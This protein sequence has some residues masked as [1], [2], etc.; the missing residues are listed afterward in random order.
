MS[1]GQL[2]VELYASSSRLESDMGKAAQI[3]ESRTRAMDQA[4][5]RARKSIEGIGDAAGRIGR[6]EGMRQAA[7]EMEHLS[8]TTVGARREMLVL[9]HEILTGNYKR[10]MGSFMVLGERM[11]WMSKIAPLLSAAM[12][13]VGIALGVAAGGAVALAVAFHQAEEESRKFQDAL[14]MTGHY[15]GVTQGQFNDMARRTAEASGL[16]VKEA[17]EMEMA[18]VSSG[19]FSGEAL[20]KVTVLAAK[21]SEVT[22]QKAEEVVRE[23]TRMTDG[24]TKYALESNRQYHFLDVAM[25]EHIKKLE[26]EGRAEDAEVLV[27][28][29]LDKKFGDTTKNVGLLTGAINWLS[30]AWSSFKSAV[31]GGSTIDDRIAQLQS[32]IDALPKSG[33]VTGGAHPSDARVRLVAALN[34][35][36]KEKM[37]QDDNA[38]LEQQK[39][40]Q[41]DRDVANREFYDK[42]IKETRTREQERADAIAD[43]NR[44]A[45]QSQWSPEMR[46]KAIA[47]ANERYKD[48]GAAAGARA[49]LGAELKPLEDQITAE[50]R[51]LSQREQVL[52][53]YY[54][55]NKLSIEGFY[56]TQ[57]TVIRA[58]IDRIS[59][60][61]DREIASLLKFASAAKD[62]ATKTEALTKAH[63]LADK[64][65]QAIQADREKLAIV[66]EGL[67][68]DTEAYRESVEKLNAELAKQQGRPSSTAAA[69]F[70]RTNRA[71]L[72]RAR[73]AGDTSTLGLASQVRD[74]IEAQD[75]MNEL[76]QEAVRIE[77]ELSLQETR[78]NLLT[79]TGQQSELQG[80][81]DIGER[82]TEAAQKLDD[83]A[84]KMQAIA[85]QT[86]LAPMILEA[87]Q[88]KTKVIELQDSANQLGKT[89]D[90]IF[91]SSFAHFID[92]AVSGTKSLKQNFLDMAN[93]IEQAITRIV[94]QDLAQRLF[95]I[96]GGG[97]GGGGL[98]GALFQLL[99]LTGGGGG[100][101]GGGSYNFTV[102]STG[103]GET[104]GMT[105]LF[106]LLGMVGGMAAGGPV[107]AGSLYEV[108][109]RGPELLTVANRTYLMM[110]DDS[111]RVTPMSDSA[112]AGNQNIFH[113]NIAV[114]P[115]T[116]RQS[117]QQQAAE[118]M[119]HANIA[120]ARLG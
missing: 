103:G 31:G 17:R 89:F 10:A 84:A 94:A 106:G 76:K 7:N 67:S 24:V 80:M 92:T 12:S 68:K 52:N 110:G 44:R 99:G 96:G 100:G 87:D 62:H 45:D 113:L 59:G 86:G 82:R 23:M 109:E 111:G 35:A 95:G 114:P 112:G 32:Q 14:Q 46:A 26:E 78:I 3:V 37:R 9:A 30:N 116:T 65:E 2:G 93:S 15:A 16:S 74:G 64:K 73:A 115:G 91:A 70:D 18:F 38:L 13:P 98:F 108:N 117:S 77:T 66:T 19:R 102:P 20:Q 58:H 104:S 69:E 105:S 28:D 22:G 81:I 48:K 57:E 51:L 34:A 107:G 71:L 1:L 33:S 47:A 60:L 25:L 54:R 63:E 79:K 21:M 4:A 88:F 36:V 43:I 101:G 11:D 72:D 119:R 6:I 83:I 27:L 40:A 39:T 118:I 61:Y 50:D 42:L 90:D 8:H 5:I 55:D 75:R 49:D 120:M 29:A 97:G 85:Q 53:R 56:T 41:K